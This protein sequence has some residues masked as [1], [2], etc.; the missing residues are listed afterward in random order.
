MIFNRIDKTEKMLQIRTFPTLLGG[1]CL[2][3]GIIVISRLAMGLLAF[4]DAAIA[5]FVVGVFAVLLEYK[6]AIFDRGSCSVIIETRRL[7]GT[8][9]RE[10]SFADID[11]IGIRTG[12][13]A[14]S[15]AGVVTLQVDGGEVSLTTMSALS[16]RKQSEVVQSIRSFLTSN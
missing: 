1:I 9:T 7:L 16:Q 15:H 8:Q 2:I 3:V 6:V 4:T 11:G 5:L 13:G 10:L 14:H 12:K